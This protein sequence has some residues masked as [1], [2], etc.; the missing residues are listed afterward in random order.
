MDWFKI[1]LL[2]DAKPT[3]KLGIRS[4]FRDLG[5]S[6]SDSILALVFN[7]LFHSF[8]VLRKIHMNMQ[9]ELHEKEPGRR[10]CGLEW[11][12]RLWRTTHSIRVGHGL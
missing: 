11:K 10:G 5:F 1:P 4:W 6:I 3:I 12:K 9:F 2:G 8:I 7:T